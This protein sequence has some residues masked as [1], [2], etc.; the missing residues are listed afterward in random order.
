MLDAEEYVEQ[1]YYYHTLRERMQ[2]GVSTQELL[3]GISREVLSTTKLP[4]ALQ[5]GGDVPFRPRRGH[6]GSGGG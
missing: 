1:A 6:G 3:I 4:M 5:F 2:E